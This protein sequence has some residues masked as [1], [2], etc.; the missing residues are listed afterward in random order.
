MAQVAAMPPIHVHTRP[1]FWTP[2]PQVETVTT[3]T[4]RAKENTPMPQPKNTPST[5]AVGNRIYQLP[6]VTEADLRRG[7]AKASADALEA[8]RVALVAERAE[9]AR[10]ADELAHTRIV[11]AV[12]ARSERYSAE[13]RAKLQAAVVYARTE[14]ALAGR[15]GA[16]DWVHPYRLAE[17]ELGLTALAPAPKDGQVLA[18]ASLAARS[19][20]A[21]AKDT[22]AR[23][24]D[25]KNVD[26]AYAKI[27]PGL[28]RPGGGYPGSFSGPF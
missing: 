5:V 3:K 18:A 19:P 27:H 11:S 14:W 21:A 26:A 24:E 4:T 10:L 12:Q 28:R 8:Q 13:D 2:D 7:Q 25:A 17:H 16:F 6:E 9:N 15:K 1:K 23:Y 20:E 22:R